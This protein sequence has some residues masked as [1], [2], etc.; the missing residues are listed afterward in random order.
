M[1]RIGILDLQGDVSEHL[2]MT[3]K[4]IKNLKIEAKATKVKK[5]D[6]IISCDALIISGGESTVIGK[7]MEKENIIK[8]LKKEKIPIMGTCAGMILLAKETD[9]KQPLLGIMDMKVQRNAFGRQKESFEEKIRILG[10]EFHGIF[11]R[12]PAVTRT[13][14]GVKILSKLNDKIIAVK[15]GK[16]IALAFH[17]EL[18]NNTLIHEHFIKEVQN[19]RNSRDSIQGR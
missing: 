3:K 9:H 10:K 16:N 18:G 17:P 1:I 4:A 15:Q 7:L 5:K 6:E 8:T 13:G 2:E 19:V 11:I 14:P 12:A